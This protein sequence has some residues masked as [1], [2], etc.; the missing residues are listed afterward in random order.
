MK[1]IV[2]GDSFIKKVQLYYEFRKFGAEDAGYFNSKILRTKESVEELYFHGVSG[3]TV[4][5]FRIPHHTLKQL[6]PDIIVIQLGSNDID[7]GSPPLNV[8]TSLV[9]HATSLRDQYKAK[10]VICSITYRGPLATKNSEDFKLK[11][12][13]CNKIIYNYCEVEE[14][15]EYFK[16][17][18]YWNTPMNTWSRDQLHPHPHKYSKNIRRAIINAM[19]KK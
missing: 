15:V 18:G 7:N 19:R 16:L 12:D 10:L 3:A 8:G 1:V 6:Q 14:S 13:M 4:G 9:Q 17:R 2:L 11:V 5:N